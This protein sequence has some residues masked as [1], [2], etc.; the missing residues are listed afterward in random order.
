[1]QSGVFS[2]SKAIDTFCPIGPWIVTGDEVPDAQALAMELRVNDQVRQ[3]GNTAQML[4]SIPHLVA[5]HSAQSYSAGDILTTGTISGVAAVQ[6]NPF[7]FYLQPG[8][9]IEAEIEGVGVLRNHV[10][11]WAAAHSTPPYST[12]LYSSTS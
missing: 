2:F 5:Y 11:P 9:S 6:P 12:D 1:M 7:E 4:I 3:R 8:D 10:V